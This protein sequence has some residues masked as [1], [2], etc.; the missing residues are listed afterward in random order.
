MELDY[1]PVHVLR[2]R[3]ELAEQTR[4]VLSDEVVRLRAQIAQM[5]ASPHL[6]VTVHDWWNA[7]V[8]PRQR[9]ESPDQKPATDDPERKPEHEDPAEPVEE[10]GALILNGSWQVP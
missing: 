5:Q 7:T 4:I 10:C 1:V 8:T 9:H 3:L 2:R 6:Q